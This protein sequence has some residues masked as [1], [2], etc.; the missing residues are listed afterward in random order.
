M[1]SV[2]SRGHRNPQNNSPQFSCVCDPLKCWHGW[3]LK[4]KFTNKSGILI[5]SE[6]KLTF[7]SIL[8]N[9]FSFFVDVVVSM[10]MRIWARSRRQN[11]SVIGGWPTTPGNVCV[12]ETSTKP[13]RSWVTCVSCTWRARNRRPS[14]WCCT[15]PW[16]WSSA[17][18][19]KSEVSAAGRAVQELLQVKNQNRIIR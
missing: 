15:R 10:R 5:D 17:W 8:T 3:T 18:S 16:R 19:N 12:C 9:V 11:V 2:A 1:M 13:L 7:M 4:S 6:K 14:C